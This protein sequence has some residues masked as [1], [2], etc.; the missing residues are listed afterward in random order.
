[1]NIERVSWVLPACADRWLPCAVAEAFTVE[2]PVPGELQRILEALDVRGRARCF[3]C[4]SPK[5]RQ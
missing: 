4:S 2:Q 5:L 3:P 1:M